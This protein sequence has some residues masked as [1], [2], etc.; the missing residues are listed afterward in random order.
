[1]ERRAARD[2]AERAARPRPRLEIEVEADAAD[3]AGVTLGEPIRLS[4]RTV[5]SDLT[6]LTLVPA[7]GVDGV[8]LISPI[9][10]VFDRPID[11]DPSPATSDDYP[12]VAGTLEVVALPDD[13]QD[14]DGAGSLLRFTPS[15]PIP[16]N[17]TF[18][19]ELAAEL[20]TLPA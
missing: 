3:A 8:A 7:D 10:V 15:G 20:T 4:F 9:A 13:P 19:V 17:T 2:R 12:E 14:D 18:E 1:M 16:P 5:T 11:P 6:A